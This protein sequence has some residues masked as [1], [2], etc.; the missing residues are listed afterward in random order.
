MELV[1]RRQLHSFCAEKGGNR[2][3]Q[4]IFRFTVIYSI[5][6]LQKSIK[7]VSL[8]ILRWEGTKEVCA[9]LGDTGLEPVTR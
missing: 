9:G 8:M 4:Y 7:S 2:N 5:C 6:N 3:P 1:G